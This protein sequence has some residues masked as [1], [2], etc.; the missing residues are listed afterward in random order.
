MVRET[1][2]ERLACPGVVRESQ[3]AADHVLQQSLARLLAQLDDHLAQDHRHVGEP[4]VGLTDVIQSSLVQQDLLQ[5]EGGHSLAQ[6]RA[7][8]HDPQTERDDLR[9]EEE[10]DHLLLVRLHEGSDD[11]EGG[12]AKVLEGPGLTDGVEEGVEVEGDVGEQEGRPG[13]R[14]RGDTLQQGEGVT[15]SVALVSSQNGRVDGGVNVDNL[16]NSYNSEQ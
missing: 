14:V 11:P 6:L 7:A 10:V 2:A 1:L 9:G 3:V 5:D 12:K 13:V 15:D 4:V 8:L 16:L